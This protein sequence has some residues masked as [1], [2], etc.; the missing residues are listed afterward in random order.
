MKRA[1]VDPA[2]WQFSMVSH[3]SRCSNSV[4]IALETGA[5]DKMNC[6]AFGP[7]RSGVAVAGDHIH[8]TNVGLF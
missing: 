6:L 5:G 8:T 2:F 3:W 7:S 4:T 1:S